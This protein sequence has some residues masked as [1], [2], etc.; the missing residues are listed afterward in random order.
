VLGRIKN[1]YEK[2][3]NPRTEEGK[4]DYIADENQID[5]SKQGTWLLLA[6]SRY[7]LGRLVR[8]LDN[9]DMPI[10]TTV[11]APPTTTKPK[12]YNLGKR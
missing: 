3:Y 6:R 9:R 12:Q 10:S 1:R 7:L 2:P 5:L 4:V 8:W 11:E